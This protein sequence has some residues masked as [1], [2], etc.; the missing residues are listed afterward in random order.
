MY[1]YTYIYIWKHIIHV[2]NHQPLSHFN[3]IDSLGPAMS[4]SG[5]SLF[6]MESPASS[7]SNL[8]CGAYLVLAARAKPAPGNPATGPDWKTGEQRLPLIWVNYGKL[9]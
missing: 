6:N 1:T 7:G 4:I 5:Q 2:P 9:W 3:H 8:G